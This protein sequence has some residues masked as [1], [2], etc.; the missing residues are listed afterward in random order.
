MPIV[1]TGGRS[2]SRYA[3]STGQYYIVYYYHVYS[4]YFLT[5]RHCFMIKKAEFCV[6]KTFFR[7]KGCKVCFIQK[8]FL[9]LLSLKKVLLL[10]VSFYF[11]YKNDHHGNNLTSRSRKICKA[12][13]SLDFLLGRK[14]PKSEKKSLCQPMVIVYIL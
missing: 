13:I 1:N 3:P 12:A 9:S 7:L 4:T 2:C 6:V 11:S 5:Q 8:A 14:I 10:Y